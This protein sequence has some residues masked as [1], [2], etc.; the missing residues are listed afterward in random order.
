MDNQFPSNSQTGPPTAPKAQPK[1]KVERVVT[2]DVIR[3]KKSLGKRFKETFTGND[4]KSVGSYVL[5]DVLIPGAKEIVADVITQGVERSLFG[6]ARARRSRF[7][8]GPVVG[9]I[10]GNATYNAYNRVTQSP[11]IGLP[12]DPRQRQQAPGL[13]G[14]V[15]QRDLQEIVLPERGQATAVLDQMI[16]VI[17]QYG[18]CSVSDLWDMLGVT[19]EH[20][21]ENWGWTDL[22]GSDVERVNEGGQYGYLLQ[23]PPCTPI[24]R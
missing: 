2:G 12:Q 16:A 1:K 7:G 20:T 4:T 14:R 10:F 18:V 23:L 19:G 5:F 22:Q 9:G 21:D 3:R 13:R 15:Q 17:S 11:P 6:E 8:G 24:E